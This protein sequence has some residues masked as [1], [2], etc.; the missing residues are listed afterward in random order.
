MGLT[1]PI[2]PGQTQ[3]LEQRLL[4]FPRCG[5]DFNETFWG[6]YSLIMQFIKSQ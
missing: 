2:A 4:S 5:P 3:S 6:N 1:S